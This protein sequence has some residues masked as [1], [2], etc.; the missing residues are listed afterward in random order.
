MVPTMRE[1]VMPNG[2]P[3]EIDPP[4]GFS[5]SMGMPSVSRQ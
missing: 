1:P 4:F 5:L 3:I 2:C